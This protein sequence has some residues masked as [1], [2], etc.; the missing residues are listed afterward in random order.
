MLSH[1]AEWCVARV[2]KGEKKGG[3]RNISDNGMLPSPPFFSQ[4]GFPQWRTPFRIERSERRNLIH[5]K[6]LMSDIII[7][8]LAING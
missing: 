3:V 1:F 8:Y 5:T 7:I 4:L 2:G 6:T